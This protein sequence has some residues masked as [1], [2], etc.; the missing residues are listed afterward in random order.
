[1]TYQDYIP[2]VFKKVSFNDRFAVETRGLW[3]LKNNSRGGPFLSYI[4]VD[5]LTNRLYYIEGFIMGPGID[6]KREF[7]RQLEAVLSS[8]QSVEKTIKESTS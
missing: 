5:E 8:F 1:M 3:K 7:M 2:P 6:K 4:F